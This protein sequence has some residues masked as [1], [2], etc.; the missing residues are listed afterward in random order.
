MHFLPISFVD[1]I[2]PNESFA[3]GCIV[4]EDENEQFRLAV[5]VSDFVCA[6]YA[7][8]NYNEDESH[9]KLI[10]EKCKNNAKI[11]FREN[12]RLIADNIPR[13]CV[14]EV[15]VIYHQYIGNKE[16]S[17]YECSNLKPMLDNIIGLYKHNTE[18]YWFVTIYDN[19]Y[20]VTNEKAAKRIYEIISNDCEYII[21]ARWHLKS[22][23]LHPLL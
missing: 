22:E 8:N 2:E 6:I 4:Y 12:L 3:N 7:W 13:T 23:C 19:A 18:N 20:C 17:A 16:F 5:P 1:S 15:N 11:L 10:V 14:N 9:R 21:K